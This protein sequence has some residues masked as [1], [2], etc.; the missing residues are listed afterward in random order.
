M[1]PKDW[2]EIDG[3]SLGAILLAVLGG[4]AVTAIA[5]G[6][7]PYHSSNHDEAVYLQQA[8]M[9]LEGRL[10]LKPGTNAVREAVHPWFFVESP[11]GFYSKYSPVPA[12][13]FAI[14]VLSGLPRLVLG[15]ISMSIALL[16]YAITTEAFDRRTGLIATGL[17][18]TAPLYL[19]TSAVFL[20]YAPTTALLL[21]FILAYIRT[22]RASSSRYAVLAGLCVGLAFFARP[23][24]AVLVA[25]PFIIHAGIQLVT[26]PSR[27]LRLHGVIGAI[28]LVFVGITLGYNQILTGNALLFPYEAFAPLDGLGFGRRRILGHEI[29]YTPS[30]ALRANAI[31]ISVFLTEWSIA[32]PLGAVLATAGITFAYINQSSEISSTLVEFSEET[33]RLL[34]VAMMLTVI[35]GNLYFWGNLNIL[36]DLQDPTDGLITVFG[37]FYH[38]DLLVPM[39]AFAAYGLTH[40]YSRLPIRLHVG[41][42]SLDRPG[43]A[44]ILIVF[45]VVVGILSGTA[46]GPPLQKNTA[47][48][49]KYETAYEPFAATEFE[50]ALV[51]LPPA[52]GEWLNHPFQWLRNTPGFDGP[53][54]YAISRTPQADFAVIDAFTS[55]SVYRYRYRGEWTPDPTEHVSPRLEQTRRLHRRTLQAQTAV[56]IPERIVRVDA[57]ITADETVRRYRYTESLRPELVVP[58]RVTPERAMIDVA[59]SGFER[60]NSGND[61]GVAID[62]PTE[63]VLTVTITAPSG[64]TLTYREELRVRPDG[65]SLEVLWP[66]ADSTCR[67][68]TDCGLEGTYLPDRPDTRP[69][70]ITLNTTITE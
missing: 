22:H 33:I 28:G 60:E 6:V 36:G 39:A 35:G 41:N 67:L 7:F 14:G 37:P 23:Y 30:L 57:A 46:I 17:V 40:G 58:W 52:Y 21:G 27:S 1:T 66:P 5:M 50:N 54:V 18:I 59:D 24:T 12:G 20:P 42:L 15:A 2:R 11:E 51:F 56:G 49:E 3:Y 31:V 8:A 16:T 25:A 64:G 62:G 32:P 34:L 70:G 9:L 69:D 44:S 38:F 65:T 26:D 48:T 29:I 45:V 43:I 61:A 47:Y 13:I 10:Y 68:V 53:V 55:R 4:G 63:V 19:L